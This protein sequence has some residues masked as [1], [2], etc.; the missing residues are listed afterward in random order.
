MPVLV[1]V[2]RWSRWVDNFERSHGPTS[3]D[4][5]DGALQGAAEDGSTFVARLPFAASYAGPATAD[6]L[7]A[8]V[9][10]PEDWGVLLVRKGGFAMA[11][12]AGTTQGESKTGQRHVQGRTKAGGQSQQRF[13]RR[14]DNQ[15][16][17]AYEAAADHAARILGS[18]HGPVVT[19]GDRGAVEEVLEDPRLRGVSVVPPWLAVPDPRRSVLDQAVADA[20]SLQV[21]VV[22]A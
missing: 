7:A 8:A 10:V 13:A 21:E 9:T 22:N 18:L 19:G 2:A 1:P 6:G 17:Q 4:V 12:L 11:R 16:R 14:R 3:Y 5:T 15:A 20:T